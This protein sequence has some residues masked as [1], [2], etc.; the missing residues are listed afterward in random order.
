MP[1]TDPGF[2][3]LAKYLS[4]FPPPGRLSRDQFAKRFR[5]L[6]AKPQTLQEIN[7]FVPVSAGGRTV[8]RGRTDQRYVQ[9]QAIIDFFYDVLIANRQPYLTKFYEAYFAFPDPSTLNWDTARLN[10]LTPGGSRDRTRGQASGSISVQRNDASRRMI[11]NLFH[12]ELLEETRVTNTVKSTD[13]FWGSF[14][15]MYNQLELPDRMFAPSSIGLCLRA[16]QRQQN[17]D[18]TNYNNLFYLFQ[19]YQPKASIFNPYAIAW[20]LARIIEPL[21]PQPGHSRTLFTPV[22][23]WA[24]YLV[25]MMHEPAY[26]EYVGVDVMPSV[27][28]KTERLGKWYAQTLQIRKQ[29]KIY[30]KPSE[31][32]ARDR[33]FLS[34]YRQHFTTVL[35]CPPYFD[36][37]EY[38]SGQQSTQTY[39]AYPDWLEGY[40][41]PTVQMCRTVLQSGGVM[42]VILNDYESLAGQK[43]PIVQDLTQIMQ[44]EG[45]TLLSYYFLQNRVS[46]L[47]VNNKD[48]TERLFLFRP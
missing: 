22:L 17:A 37:E 41:R 40:W 35:V 30:C 7:N 48:R 15:R 16:K 34:K 31:Q 18:E 12:R 33:T 3:T 13:S 43:Y 6:Y 14:R 26:T 10:L 21:L 5:I 25:A 11:R 28:R 20:I 46:P 29:V 38:A 1:K 42:G 45:F 19:A 27:C 47:R 36:M 4:E 9:R 8:L 44:Q 32:L 39:P 23:S 2:L 24:S